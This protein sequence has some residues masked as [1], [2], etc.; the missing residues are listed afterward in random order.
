MENLNHSSS[1]N[2]DHTHIINLMEN[3]NHSSSINH[4]HTHTINLDH[5][6]YNKSYGKS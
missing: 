4:D 3:L 6:T 5:F 1:I 2:L